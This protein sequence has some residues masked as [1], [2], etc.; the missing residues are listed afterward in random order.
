MRIL[1]VEDDTSLAEAITDW[2]RLD[3]YAVDCLSR[4]DLADTALKTHHYDCVL[5]D[6]GLPVLDGDKVLQRVRARQQK[7]PVIYITAR[8]TLSDRVYGLDAGADDYLVKPFDL[9]EMS[10]RIRVVIRRSCEQAQTLM[11]CGSLTLD[12]SS[13]EVCFQGKTVTLTVRG[14]AVLHMLMRRPGQVF[15]RAQLEESLYGWGDE[16][17]SNAVEV[18]IHH[19]RKKMDNR[20]IRTIRNQG[21]RL[22]TL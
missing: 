6:R 8:D 22:E 1:V 10:A 5:L 7:T 20:L 15:S 2:L 18:Y 14:F 13:H 9:A 11:V 17:E 16:V 12:P 4:G 19:L 21:Y 3:G